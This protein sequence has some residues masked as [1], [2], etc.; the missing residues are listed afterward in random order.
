MHKQNP[1]RLDEADTVII[2]NSS[3]PNLSFRGVW[4][5]KIWFEF[6]LNDSDSIWFKSDGPAAPDVVL[7]TT[8]TVQ[9]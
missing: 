2:R 6:E 1:Q 3:S 4:S 9:Q 8:L 7:Q 5:F